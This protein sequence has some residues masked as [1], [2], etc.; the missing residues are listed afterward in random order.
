MRSR[1]DRPVHL[2]VP[3]PMTRRIAWH[4]FVPC[5]FALG[6]VGAA[7]VFAQSGFGSSPAEVVTDN[8]QQATAEQGSSTSAT[9]P[10]QRQR[11]EDAWWT[12]PVIAN[13]PAPLPKGHVYVESYLY[14]AKTSGVDG[15]GSQTYLLYGLSDRLT[16]GMRPLFGYT[17]LDGGGGSSRIGVGDLTLH[18]HYALT[19]YNPDKRTPAIAIAVEETLPIGRYDR[20]NRTSNGFGNGAY[21]T[22]LALYAQQYFWL[23]NGRLLRG[24]LNVAGSFS[25]R[26]EIRD[27]SVYGTPEGFHGNARP[28]VSWSIDNAWEYSVTRNWVLAVDFYY[29]H[30][31]PA[32]VR[33]EAGTRMRRF[34][35]GVLDTFAVVPAVEYNWSSRVGVIVGARFIAGRGHNSSSVTPV[36]ALSVLI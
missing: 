8:D 22:T 6:L 3:L 13:S 2:Q 14:D 28:G 16:V 24:R 30:D 20:L 7:P 36:V 5:L 17:H 1:A 32:S 35:T 19:T 11:L 29:R 26:A 4:G 31:E 12:G 15:F 33:D 34:G 23:G 27:L 25:S 9:Q 10:P 21:T 18:A